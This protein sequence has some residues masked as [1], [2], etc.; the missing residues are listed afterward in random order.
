MLPSLCVTVLAPG[1]NF[2]QTVLSFAIWAIGLDCAAIFRASDTSNRATAGLAIDSAALPTVSPLQP[3]ERPRGE[4]G[5]S[6]QAQECVRRR[7][8]TESEGEGTTRARAA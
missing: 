6:A 3:G 1:L 8:P 7:R 4:K 2:N 5:R